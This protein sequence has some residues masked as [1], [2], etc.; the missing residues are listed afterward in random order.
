MNVT[1]IITLE[2]QRVWGDGYK[3]FFDK[4][5]EAPVLFQHCLQRMCRLEA[6]T[7]FRPTPATPQQTSTLHLT[8]NV[9][10][11]AY[12]HAHVWEFRHF[13]LIRP[14]DSR[15]LDRCHAHILAVRTIDARLCIF[16]TAQR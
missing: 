16:T 1:R 8:S 13:F 2:E 10:T 7:P 4:H 12:I 14:R 11:C 5:G 15:N 9:C 6:E 3:T